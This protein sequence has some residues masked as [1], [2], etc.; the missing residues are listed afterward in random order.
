MNIAIPRI[1]ERFFRNIIFRITHIPNK[2][3]IY[4]TFDDGPTPEITPW[5]LDVLHEYNAKATFFCI[6]KN[7]DRNPEIYQRILDE[8]HSVGNHTYSHLRGRKLTYDEYVNDI[9][10]ASHYIKSNLFRPPYASFTKNQI[11]TLSKKYNIILWS[12][13]S[14]DYNKNISP[15]E[16]SDTITNNLKNGSIIVKA[17]PNMSF[18]LTNTLKKAKK[19][20]YGCKGI[21]LENKILLSD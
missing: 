20:G 5:V 7:I 19:D 2:P 11:K 16:C 13:L 6:A 1:L 4:I 15:Q 14:R 17:F 3:A 9:E 18:A 12:I 10:L 21:V 8:G